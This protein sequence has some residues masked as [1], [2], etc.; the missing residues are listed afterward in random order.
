M[1]A[2][3]APAKIN[4]FLAVMSKRP[5]GFHEI[6]SLIQ[7][8]DLHDTL[9]FEDSGEIEVI[10]DLPIEARE[11]LVFKAASALREHLKTTRG[12]RVR[13]HKRIPVAAGLGGGSSDAAS[14][15]KGLC[16]LWGAD[17]PP[18]ELAA[19]AA[20]IGSDVPFFLGPSAGLAEGRG[21]RL[22]PAAITRGS[23]LLLVNPHCEVSAAWAY[24]RITEYSTTSQ[25]LD[26]LVDGLNRGDFESLAPL[27]T[28]GLEGPVEAAHPA[29]GEIKRKLLEEGA[30]LSLMSGSG[31]TVFGV[32]GSRREA[33][34]AAEKFPSFWTTVVD[35]L[36]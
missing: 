5:D 3:D 16:A 18:G 6:R 32:F 35:T 28:N 12:A 7:K 31:P 4:W 36:T 33:G 29:V 8:V 26:W 30:L 23:C 2:L 24:G 14:A 9:E 20:T 10:A 34:Q 19:L 11:N 17:V 25:S 22:T 13:L 15:L 27:L 21:E 1:L